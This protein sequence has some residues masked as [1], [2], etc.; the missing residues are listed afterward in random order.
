MKIDIS[1]LALLKIVGVALALWFLYVI[2]EVLAIL[3]VAIIL[4]SAVDPIVNWLTK[5]KIPR[6][7]SI[8]IIYII[9]LNSHCNLFHP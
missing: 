1:L 3:F 6:L 8:V 7:L 9:L 5:K 4:A 2:G